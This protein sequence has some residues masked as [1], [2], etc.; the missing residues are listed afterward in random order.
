MQKKYLKYLY[1]FIGVA[2]S[3]FFIGFWGVSFSLK[4]MQE[5][6]LEI[7]IEANK[8]HAE[9]MARILAGE[10][11]RGASPEEVRK[12]FQESIQGTDTEEGFLCM[13]NNSGKNVCHPRPEF[14]GADSRQMPVT[15][16]GNGKSDKFSD[17]IIEGNAFGGWIESEAANLSEVVFMTPVEGTDWL[18]ASHENIIEVKT[19]ISMF[20]RQLIGGFVA[21]G[22]VIALASAIVARRIN[23]RYEEQIDAQRREIEENYS[24]LQNLHSV[25]NNQK[26]AIEEQSKN[27]RASITYAKRIQRAML[28]TDSIMQEKLTEHFVLWRPRDIVSGDFYWFR[29]VEHENRTLQI[30]VAADSTGHGVPGA[31][32]SILGITTLNDIVRKGTVSANGI[33]EELRKTIKT[34]LKQDGSIGSTSDGMDMALL[35]I[36]KAN[37]KMEYAGA[38]NPLYIFRDGQLVEHSAT[39]NPIGIH[40]KEKKFEKHEI[41]VCP[42]DVFYIFSDGIPDQ[43]GG[44]RG[45]KLKRRAFKEWLAEVHHLPMNEQK[46]QIE[47]KLGVWMEKTEQIDDMLL[48]GIRV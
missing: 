12:R 28:P 15:F 30:L 37:N 23:L 46:K 14:V 44:K 26:E 48:I 8:R 33:L 39:R 17:F 11:K 19:S 7:Q 16:H 47:D 18:L 43:H 45:S 24:Q 29:E 3:V 1:T 41:E 10:I 21:L 36:D 20:R 31:F 9:N 2:S 40:I 38:Y 35:V 13:F 25:V 34:T 27:T 6:Y 42:S 5:K 4:L 32:M 22:L